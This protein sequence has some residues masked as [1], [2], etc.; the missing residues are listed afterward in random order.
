MRNRERLALAIC[1]G[2]VALA[3][4]LASQNATKAKRFDGF[5]AFEW[6]A[7]SGK[8]V[9]EVPESRLGKD[10]LYVSWLVTGLGS[11]PVGLDRGQVG[12]EKVVRFERVGPKLLLIERNLRYRARSQDAAE[13]RAVEESFASSVLWAG[14]IDKSKGGVLHVDMT[15]FFVRDARGVVSVLSRSGQGG[16]SL[17]QDRS[18]IWPKACRA[19]PRNSEIEVLL[20]FASKSPGARVRETTPTPNSVSLR[21]RHSLVALPEPGYKP[22][23]FDPRSGC[24]SI[25]FADYAAPLD[26]PLEKRWIQRHRLE[27]QDPNAAKSKPKRPIVYYVDRGAPEPVRSA[28]VE[29]ASWWKA[30]FEAAGFEDA[31]EVR[32]MPEGADPLDVRYNVIQ[33]VHR[34]TRG[35]SYG[36]SI[37]DPRTGEILKGHVSLGSLRVRQDRMIFEGLSAPTGAQASG[38]LA[39]R[40]GGRRAAL[41]RGDH[42]PCACGAGAGP[43]ASVLA[44]SA[45]VDPIPTALA[46][47][48]Q[49]SAHEVGHTLGFAHNFAAST[50]GRASVMD[51]PAPLVRLT[52]T[53]E[54]D[55]GQAYAVG[56]GDWDKVTVRY[57]Y[58]QFAN[59]DQEAAGLAA[60]LDDAKQRGMIFVTD[61]DARSIGTAHPLASLWD[62]GE[63]PLRELPRV[64]AVRRAALERF[65][66]HC[67][68]EGRPRAE[69]EALLVPLYLGHRYQVIAT[70]K[71]LG[72]VHFDYGVRTKDIVAK[73][74]RP[75]PPLR[76]TRALQALLKT[77]T[78]DELLLPSK[79]FAQIVPPSYGRNSK[80]ELFPGRTGA[81]FDELAAARVAA[82]QALDVLLEPSRAARMVAQKARDPR[83]PGFA[84]LA[85]ALFAATWETPR[86]GK[87]REGARR[88]AIRRV[89]ERAVLDR[90]L[91]MADDPSVSADVR[92]ICALSI[93][94]DMRPG[95]RDFGDTAEKAHVRRA[96]EDVRRFRARTHQSIQR[97]RRLDAPP[98]SPI[99]ATRRR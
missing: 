83:M 27:K 79:L 34:S 45:R 90:F 6:Q 7:D 91:R 21:Q 36:R 14:K 55:F 2:L 9:L 26:A 95:D 96:E 66:P 44:R 65:G 64:L 23:A 32:V 85:K 89:V 19:F 37:V 48:R 51:Y 61:Q 12:G 71:L 8:L 13:R 24:F 63:D 33:W 97:P 16:F 41:H 43:D 42:G 52:K 5:F 40:L 62:N 77:L 29:G 35:W 69:L 84:D 20:T 81:P 92:A 4:S 67:V 50:F 73:P 11:N 38:A 72:G 17:D 56:I 98:G 93:V 53:G 30:A 59:A 31:F 88:A 15:K 47:L 10:F 75:V 3:P 99:G 18:T 82:E 74:T 87:R 76:Q 49:L 68:P 70:G 58:T 1:G 86:Q 28:L 46:R 22:R 94:Q 54:F 60:I 39:R 57:A 80:A 78:P 25:A